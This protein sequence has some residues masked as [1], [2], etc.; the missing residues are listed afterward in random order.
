MT[1]PTVIFYRTRNLLFLV[2]SISSSADNV[3][4]KFMLYSINTYLS[5]INPIAVFRKQY[6]H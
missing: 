1:L 3:G 2:P 6:L 4:S 5:L